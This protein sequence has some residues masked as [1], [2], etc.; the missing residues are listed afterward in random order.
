MRRAAT[1]GV[2]N[3]S[4]SAGATATQ[5]CS[6]TAACKFKTGCIVRPKRCT[7]PEQQSGF[8][9]DA[10]LAEGAGSV[11][12]H[13]LPGALDFESS[14][15][16]SWVALVSRCSDVKRTVVPAEIRHFCNCRHFTHIGLAWPVPLP[17]CYQ[18][19]TA[20][21]RRDGPLIEDRK[22]NEWSSSRDRESFS[23][24]LSESA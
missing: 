19:S 13:A 15:L 9:Q 14:L 5:G 17:K 2:H 7:I 21:P 8:A 23:L 11:N 3:E 24:H 6:A 12:R 4:S 18:F 10:K 1:T 16:N 22:R 20:L